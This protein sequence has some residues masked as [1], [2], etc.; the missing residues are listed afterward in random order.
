MRTRSVVRM[1]LLG[2]ILLAAG[3]IVVALVANSASATTRPASD[4]ELTPPA[5]LLQLLSVEFGASL[6]TV[7]NATVDRE[8]ADEIA[9]SATRLH[10]EYLAA[11]ESPDSQ[12]LV[13]VEDTAANR[14]QGLPV[15]GLVWIMDYQGLTVPSIGGPVTEDGA[16]AKPSL[17]T[18]GVVLLDAAT[19]SF[20][21]SHW[22]GH[23]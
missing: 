19:G 5:D 1:G 10:S 2:C 11:D 4:S 23:S 21:A 20:L 18:R 15:G 16:P 13:E 8:V 12:Y 9:A 17:I 7:D 6:R 22:Q 14:D 3:A